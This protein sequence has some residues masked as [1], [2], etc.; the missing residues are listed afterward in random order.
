MRFCGL[1]NSTSLFA[2]II[3][4]FYTGCASLRPLNSDKCKKIVVEY[5]SQID[6][7][8]F[9]LALL[10]KQRI[11]ESGFFYILSEKGVL[12]VHPAEILVGNDFSKVP[13][14]RLILSRD[15]GVQSDDLGGIA[16]TVFFR[17]LASG[18][19]LCLTINTAEL[20]TEVK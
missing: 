15:S 2:A 18:S 4:L 5:A 3:I 17:R 10:P 6:A 11:G 7:G 16:R 8:R 13:Q 14:V 12:L 20:Q 9:S 1:K 19:M